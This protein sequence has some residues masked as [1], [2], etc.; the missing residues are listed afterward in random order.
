MNTFEP[1]LRRLH[2]EVATENLPLALASFH[3][4]R[5]YIQPYKGVVAQV[6]RDE[7]GRANVSEGL[8]RLLFL[9]EAGHEDFVV[10]FQQLTR[11]VMAKGVED[12]AFYRYLRLARAQR[13]RRQSRPFGDERR[14]LPPSERTARCT[15]PTE[16][17]DHVHARHET[18]AR[19]AL[20]H[21]GPQL[22]ARRVG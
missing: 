19:C 2:Q 21:R 1:E 10:R 18:L 16:P 6:D 5:T 13:G 12:T 14:G 17:P 8:R 3:V 4:Y 15:R 7:I 11:P 9:Q 20:A 22:A